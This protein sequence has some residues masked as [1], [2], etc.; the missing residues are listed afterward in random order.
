MKSKRKTFTLLVS[1]LLVASIS[2]CGKHENIKE[3]NT[4]KQSS[5]TTEE[6]ASNSESA[7]TGNTED[8]SE[9]ETTTDDAT[10][11][12]ATSDETTTAKPEEATTTKQESTTTKKQESTT[13]K[14]Q[15]TTTPQ[16]TTTKK[17]EQTTETTKKPDKTTEPTTTKAQEET[18]TASNAKVVY[19]VNVKTAGGM[20]LEDIDV[21]IYADS[22]KKDLKDFRSTS[23]N[24]TAEFEL[25]KSSNYVISLEGVPAGYDV[26]ASYAFS[27]DTANIT[28]ISSI[29]KGDMP[30]SLEVG[31]VMYDMTVK[32]SDGVEYTLSEILKDKDMVMLNFWFSTCYYCIQEF[33]HIDQAYGEY[34][35]SIEILALNPLGEGDT[36]IQGVKDDNQLSFP[37]AGC[38]YNIATTFGITGY[39]T[40]VVI[41]RYG[42]ICMVEAGGVPNTEYWDMLFAHFTGD[43]YEQ[44]LLHNGISDIY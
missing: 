6:S 7:D 19:T 24:G 4:D 10:T 29:I 42:V 41:D 30:S 44:K 32:S 17:S 37:M 9:E 16:E 20:A 38:P 2:A 43:N 22:T 11:G 28:L 18:T 40:T 39:P 25:V 23:S 5:S 14:K 8:T 13:T 26:K 33:P 12:E 1:I 36:T 15:E 3:P 31:D 21:Y 27:G 34:A 35:D